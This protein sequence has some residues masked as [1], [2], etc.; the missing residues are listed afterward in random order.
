MTD[1]EINAVASRV[2]AS[3]TSRSGFIA[4]ETASDL[5]FDGT[6]VIH[7]TARYETM[8]RPARP[9]DAM[10]A[11]RAE[12]LEAGEMRDVFLTNHYRD[13]SWIEEDAA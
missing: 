13:E 10:H 2:L 9:L 7:V 11:I 1:D 3:D 8:P 4:S 12:L 6:P 5:D